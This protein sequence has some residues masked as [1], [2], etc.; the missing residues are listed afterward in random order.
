MSKNFE[1]KPPRIGEKKENEV[2][3]YA[4]AIPNLLINEETKKFIKWVNGLDGFLGIY[5][6]YPHGNLLIFKT[7]NDAKGGRNLIRAR[8]IEV[9]K[10]IGEVFIEK[11]YV[12]RSDN[13]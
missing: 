9:G 1:W 5:P 11:Q 8:G 10:N 12:E 6:H 2:V 3:C 4:F 13:K 7:E